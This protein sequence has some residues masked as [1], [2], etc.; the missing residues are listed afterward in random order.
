M[1]LECK[2]RDADGIVYADGK[3]VRIGACFMF[4]IAVTVSSVWIVKGA[5][6][7]GEIIR[8]W[9]DRS[10]TPA[11]MVFAMPLLAGLV[12]IGFVARSVVRSL[13]DAFQF[14]EWHLSPRRVEMR[15]KAPFR[16]LRSEVFDSA[17]VA[18]VHLVDEPWRRRAERHCLVWLELPDGRKRL[19]DHGREAAALQSLAEELAA[20]LRV[21]LA[22]PNDARLS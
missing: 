8:S 12:F 11:Q 21:P 16:P 9:S 13:I 7:V 4:A 18:R 2:E 17:G 6:F 5:G 15:I 22:S 3:H 1:R 10:F 20:S 14:R 19:V